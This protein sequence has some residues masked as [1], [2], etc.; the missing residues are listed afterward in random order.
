[1]GVVP[2]TIAIVRNRVI[3][4][5]YGQA[6]EMFSRLTRRER[7]SFEGLVLE[8]EILGGLDDEPG[9]LRTARNLVVRW[10]KRAESH[11]LLAEALSVRTPRKARRHFVA[12]WRL[13]SN[14][15]SILAEHLVDSFL[16]FLVFSGDLDSAWRLFDEA[17]KHPLIGRA[18]WL[19]RL[20]GSL[21]GARKGLREGGPGST[22]P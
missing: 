22:H 17:V 18:D 6:R 2:P 4:G 13:F 16:T 21:L 14:Q 11:L 8:T 12:A 9:E 1:M 5:R 20:R 7:S 3:S 19:L 10:P 15:D